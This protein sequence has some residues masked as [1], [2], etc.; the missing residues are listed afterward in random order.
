MSLC[1]VLLLLSPTPHPKKKTFVLSSHLLTSPVCS[2]LSLA[3]SSSC[4]PAA[5]LEDTVRACSEGLFIPLPPVVFL[6]PPLHYFLSVP[7]EQFATTC[8]P[9]SSKPSRNSRFRVCGRQKRKTVCK[10]S[11]RNQHG[12]T[13]A[14]GAALLATIISLFL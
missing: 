11:R 3:A 1:F 9:A 8:L 2:L 5:N 10:P 4:L 7:G 12:R 14:L 6:P 13:V